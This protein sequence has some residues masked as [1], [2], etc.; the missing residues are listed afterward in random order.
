MATVIP[1]DLDSILEKSE[2][3]RPAGRDEPRR[4]RTEGVTSARHPYTCGS[5][6]QHNTLQHRGSVEPVMHDKM[7]LPGTRGRARSAGLGVRVFLFP[8]CVKAHGEKLTAP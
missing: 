8:R 4:M 2:P 3:R 7:G 6:P 1:V 5:I